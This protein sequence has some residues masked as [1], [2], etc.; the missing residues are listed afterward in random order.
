MQEPA[1][2]PERAPEAQ[3]GP[4][5]AAPRPGEEGPPVEVPP[6]PLTEPCA[7]ISMKQTMFSMEV[8]QSQQQVGTIVI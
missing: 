2:A 6:Q 7:V 5:P 3:M 1:V 4:P 8:S